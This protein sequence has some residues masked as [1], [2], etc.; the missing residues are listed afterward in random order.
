MLAK[1][2]GAPRTWLLIGSTVAAS[3]GLAGTTAAQ[4]DFQYAPPAIHIE[5]APD[6]GDNV[7]GIVPEVI[8]S[9][10]PIGAS[11]VGGPVFF[12][13]PFGDDSSS[14]LKWDNVQK[15]LDLVDEQREKIRQ[16]QRQMQEQ[17]QEHFAEMREQHQRR[18]RELQERR[19]GDGDAAESRGPAGS[20]A[21]GNAG[22]RFAPGVVDA[23]TDFQKTQEVMR[24][25]REELARKVDDVLLPHQKKRLEEISLHMKMK[26]RG[27]SGA[28]VDT[29]LAKS[30]DIDEAQKERI[31]RKAIE[32]QKDLEEK[33]AKL[34]EEARQE[35]LDELSPAQKRKLEDLLGKDFDDR[36]QPI[37]RR[38]IGDDRP[39]VIERG[40]RP[41]ERAA[42]RGRRDEPDAEGDGDEA[43][44]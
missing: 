33:I 5:L 32:V 14:L 30:L 37:M 25:L 40:N 41:S 34:R 10:G 8:V 27:T 20:P 13:E 28:L 18:V 35:I 21:G 29:E 39:R 11:P 15:E 42:D 44:R 26:R 36:P 43:T 3:A 19:G 23:P 2:I 1:F 12:A 4:E 24:E 9:P 6:A 17:M 31:R 22:G 38:R 16:A 7:I